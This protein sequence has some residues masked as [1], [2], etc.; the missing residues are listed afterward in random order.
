[1]AGVGHGIGLHAG[2]EMVVLGEQAGDDLVRGVVGVG[3]E[4]EGLFDGGDAEEDEHLVE[5]GAAVPIGPDHAFVDA[6]GKRHGEHG[7]GGLNQQ[8][9]MSVFK[10]YEYRI[11]PRRFPPGCLFGCWHAR[12]R[13]G[14]ERRLI[15][16][17][18]AGWLPQDHGA[19]RA[20]LYLTT[21]VVF[22]A[23]VEGCPDLSRPP[24]CMPDDDPVVWLAGGTMLRDHLLGLRQS[25]VTRV[26]VAHGRSCHLVTPL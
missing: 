21:E 5:Q 2:E 25:A 3:D 7:G 11:P 15:M 16:L 18:Y 12:W 4:I 9:V 1:M 13:A 17:W 24:P 22:Q 26:T 8:A 6:R 23:G 20:C 10:G 19:S 14:T